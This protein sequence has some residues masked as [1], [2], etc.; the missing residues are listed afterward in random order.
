MREPTCHTNSNTQAYRLGIAVI[1]FFHLLLKYALLRSPSGECAPPP[2]AGRSCEDIPDQAR[3][4]SNTIEQKS[5]QVTLLAATIKRLQLNHT[6][7]Q[8]TVAS[9]LEAAARPGLDLNFSI[10]L[11]QETLAIHLAMQYLLNENR[12][13]FQIQVCDGPPIAATDSS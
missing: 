4:P 8:S 2:L 10:T 3:A 7:A 12:V 6:S 1:T 9:C 5:E 11:T 13:V